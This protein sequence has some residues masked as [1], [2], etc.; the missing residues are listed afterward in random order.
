MYIEDLVRAYN[1]MLEKNDNAGEVYNFG[2]GV[3]TS[4]KD[5]AEY[6]AKNIGV[7][8]EYSQARPGEVSRFCADITKAKKLGFEPKFNIW[9]GI[10]RYID[11]KR[12]QKQ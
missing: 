12:G 8:V 9:Q 7:S 6:I 2:T 1:L 3:E 10:D 11:W 5:I 4:V